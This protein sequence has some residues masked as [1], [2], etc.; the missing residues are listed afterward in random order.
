MSDLHPALG[1]LAALVGTW[2]GEG[3]GHYPTIAPFAYRETVTFA[4][5]GR[6]VLSYAQRTWRA[7]SDEPLHAESGWL[8]GQLEGRAELVVA[9]PTGLAETSARSSSTVR[10]PRCCAAPVRGPSSTCD[11]GSSSP[12]TSCATTSG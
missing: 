6:P 9:Q 3:E 1:A 8:R 2:S 4:A 5:S 10:G 11:G 7:G 12:A